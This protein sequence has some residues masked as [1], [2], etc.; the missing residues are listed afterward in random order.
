MRTLTLL[1]CAWCVLLQFACTSEK[2]LE[3]TDSNALRELVITTPSGSRTIFSKYDYYM[4]TNVSGGGTLEGLA[5]N[6]ATL[7]FSRSHRITVKAWYPDPGT[8]IVSNTFSIAASVNVLFTA[9]PVY[10]YTNT[11]R[12][13][14]WDEDEGREVLNAEW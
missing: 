14:A 6:S 8:I 7:T 11:L 13:Q 4:A 3:P 2:P 9:N 1:C 10:Y 5:M 12:I